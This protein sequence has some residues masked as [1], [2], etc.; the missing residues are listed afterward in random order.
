MVFPKKLSHIQKLFYE[1]SASTNPEAQHNI[2]SILTPQSLNI[3]IR[4][5]RMT[6]LVKI[7]AIDSQNQNNK[8]FSE[9]RINTG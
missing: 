6:T 9:T 2:L 5:M 1:L 8:K 7:I 4:I 3:E